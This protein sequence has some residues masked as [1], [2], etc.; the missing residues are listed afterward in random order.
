MQLFFSMVLLVLSSQSVSASLGNG[1]DIPVDPSELTPLYGVKVVDRRTGESM[2]FYQ[3]EVPNPAQEGEMGAATPG[4]RLIKL[5]ADRKLMSRMGCK[6]HYC[7][8]YLYNGQRFEDCDKNLYSFYG[9]DYGG[10]WRMDGDGAL[11]ATMPVSNAAHNGMPAASVFATIADLPVMMVTG[12]GVGLAVASRRIRE[13]RVANV[14]EKMA[15]STRA[16]EVDE[17]PHHLFQMS[18]QVPFGILKNARSQERR[19]LRSRYGIRHWREHRND[20]PPNS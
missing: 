10:H 9:S 8:T 3:C 12:P 16:G 2:A 17:I 13:L 18:Y 7:R 14:F 6:K 20:A 5:S 1:I 4:I 11:W 19:R 15:D